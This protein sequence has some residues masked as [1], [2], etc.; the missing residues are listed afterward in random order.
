VKKDDR[1]DLSGWGGGNGESENGISF[2]TRIFPV[3]VKYTGLAIAV[4]ETAIDHV[5]RPSLLL[6]A[7]GMMGLDTVMKASGLRNGGKG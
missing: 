2:L 7:A 4:W 3:I 5:D 6:L 1:D